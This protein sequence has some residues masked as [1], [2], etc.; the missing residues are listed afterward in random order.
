[1]KNNLTFFALGLII[2]NVRSYASMPYFAQASNDRLA[3]TP[4]VCSSV[5]SC[6]YLLKSLMIEY[7]KTQQKNEELL[8]EI[9][10]LKK[11]KQAAVIQPKIEKG[12]PK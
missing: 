6:N 7:Q 8:R 10:A 2:L 3:P 1:M 9:D 11:D 12:E 4:D 5:K